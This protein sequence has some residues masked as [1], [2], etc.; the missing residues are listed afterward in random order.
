MKKKFIFIL[1]LLATLVLYAAGRALYWR[2]M[3]AAAR[4][5]E[6]TPP[7]HTVEVGVPLAFC[8]VK[9]TW[10]IPP[11]AQEG[12]GQYNITIETPLGETSRRAAFNYQDDNVVRIKLI[13][14]GPLVESGPPETEILR[15]TM[16]DRNRMADP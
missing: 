13:G 16:D 8:E 2:T 15:F 14:S 10:H 6:L 11:G 5:L 12:Y 3:Q 4:E 9:A 7:H 1:G